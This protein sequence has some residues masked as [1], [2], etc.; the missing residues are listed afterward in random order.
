M[1]IF[2][3]LFGYMLIGIPIGLAASYIY[4]HFELQGIKGACVLFLALI[5]MSVLYAIGSCL[6]DYSKEIQ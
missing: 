4:E 2:C 3:Y 5:V 6:V 1:R